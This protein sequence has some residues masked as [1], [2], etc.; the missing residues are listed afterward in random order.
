[1]RG[2]CHGITDSF[3]GS[4]WENDPN[5][6]LHEQR[7]REFTL[8]KRRNN[9]T[10]HRMWLPNK[11]NDA[12]PLE[13]PVHV[14]DDFLWHRHMK[15][16]MAWSTCVGARASNFNS[17]ANIRAH[18]KKKI[19]LY[20]VFNHRMQPSKRYPALTPDTHAI[21]HAKHTRTHTHCAL[22]PSPLQTLETDG[23]RHVIVSIPTSSQLTELPSVTQAAC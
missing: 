14:T 2:D 15:T 7:G 1:M 4:L 19:F 21:S 11:V 23:S 3:G 20:F 12:N 17:N 9:F 5:S 16:E 8:R 22:L 18:W 6:D 13:A 10:R